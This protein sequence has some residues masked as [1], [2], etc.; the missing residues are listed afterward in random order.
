MGFNATNHS[1]IEVESVL[2]IRPLQKKEKEDDFAA[3]RATDSNEMML[4][5]SII[6]NSSTANIRNAV[7]IAYSIIQIHVGSRNG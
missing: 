1:N 7:R 2:R 3:I 4:F 6:V 5:L